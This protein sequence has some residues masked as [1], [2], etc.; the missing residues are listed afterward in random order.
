LLVLVPGA[1][2]VVDPEDEHPATASSVAAA[3]TV[4]ACLLK[5]FIASGLL[6]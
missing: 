3:A 5:S 6:C 2:E 4:S 1:V